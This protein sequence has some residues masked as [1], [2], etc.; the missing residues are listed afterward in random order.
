MLAAGR[1]GHADECIAGAT[2]AA[3]DR[4]EHQTEAAAGAH[5]V[6][7]LELRRVLRAGRV[8]RA[9][10]RV[11][12]GHVR[13]QRVREHDD[14][15]ARVVAR[16]AERELPAERVVRDLARALQR[17]RRSPRR[18]PGGTGN[19]FGL[20]ASQSLAW[21]DP[22]YSSTDDDDDDDDED[23][24]DDDDDDDDEDD[25]DAYYNEWAMSGVMSPAASTDRACIPV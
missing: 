24:D 21:A 13:E 15:E 14:V 20:S 4:V 6:R 23:D 11:A 10:E 5:A 1:T 16:V 3:S 25:D 9:D 17:E 19:R 2:V 12:R 7:T 22:D 8:G 18:A